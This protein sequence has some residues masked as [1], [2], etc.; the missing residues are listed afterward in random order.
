MSSNV[1]LKD[2]PIEQVRQET[3]DTLIY[4]Y[5]HAVISEQALERRLDIVIASKDHQEIVEQVA[6]LKPSEDDQ[7]K[8]Q[9]DSTFSVQ[10]DPTAEQDSSTYTAVLST[11][12]KTGRWIRRRK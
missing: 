8:Q 10:I 11:T 1:I 7:I 6:D 5:S 12:E 2:R 3:I 4:N 9:R